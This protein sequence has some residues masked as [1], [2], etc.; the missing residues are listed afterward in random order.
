MTDFFETDAGQCAAIAKQFLEGAQVLS[1]AQRENG[2]ILFRPTLALAAHGLELMLKACLYLNGHEPETK[3]RKGHDVVS[4][5]ESDAC[6]PIKAH[7]FSNAQLAALE[8]RESNNYKDVPS[9]DEVRTL[10]EEHVIK[11]GKLHGARDYPLRYPSDPQIKAPVTPWLVRTLWR[12]ADDLVKRPG[13]F[14][15]DRCDGAG[16]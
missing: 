2:P 4:F 15:R 11:L 10:I 12:T 6:K 8:G 16:Q 1:D 5:W 14:K 9:D 7:V 3:G 13:E